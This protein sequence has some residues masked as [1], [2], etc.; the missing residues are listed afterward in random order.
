MSV[1]KVVLYGPYMAQNGFSD[2]SESLSGGGKHEKL[3]KISGN[4][5]SSSLIACV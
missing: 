2:E 5:V 1:I 4:Q 3:E